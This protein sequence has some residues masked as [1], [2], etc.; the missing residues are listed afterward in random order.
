MNLLKE[1]Y[2]E[3]QEKAFIAWLKTLPCCITGKEPS[4][5]AHVRRVSQGAGMGR[6]PRLY[7]IPLCHEAHA[8]Q[9]QYGEFSCLKIYKSPDFVKSIE[10]AKKW[11][12]DQAFFYREVFLEKIWGK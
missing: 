11:F 9:H 8:Y 7:A 6:K 4:E 3:K 12:D 1:P 2:S 5:P 10:E